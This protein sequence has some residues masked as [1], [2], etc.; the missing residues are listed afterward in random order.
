MIKKIM[1][2][3]CLMGSF[4]IW[5]GCGNPEAPV[6]SLITITGPGPITDT[7][8][9]TSTDSTIIHIAVMTANSIPLGN[10]E[11]WISYPWAIPSPAGAVQLY[12]GDNEMDS[13]MKVKT[14][15]NGAY[16]L[17]MDYLRGGGVSY[18]GS[19]Q[20]TSGIN[21]GTTE[22]SVSSGSDT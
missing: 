16:N 18:E 4:F 10:V 22:F 19:I 8:S 12:D 15:S 11:I 21:V 17:R 6:R 20:V 14:D 9:S 3:L 2:G 1:I 5:Y 7:S 13:P